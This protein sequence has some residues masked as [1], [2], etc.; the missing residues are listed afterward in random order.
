MTTKVVIELFYVMAELTNADISLL[1]SVHRVLQL[2]RTLACM[3]DTGGIGPIRHTVMQT[4]KA[5]GPGSTWTD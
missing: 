1:F 5:G 3:Y 2:C 4:D